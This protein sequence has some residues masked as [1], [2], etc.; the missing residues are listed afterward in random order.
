MSAQ[1]NEV[2]VDSACARDISRLPSEAQE[3]LAVLLDVLAVNPFDPL[4]HTKPLSVPLQGM[5]SFR[6]TRGYRVGFKFREAYV[7]QLLAVGSRDTIYER[8]QRKI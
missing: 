6:I 4:L 2:I 3:K 5:F 1:R 7:I 8:L